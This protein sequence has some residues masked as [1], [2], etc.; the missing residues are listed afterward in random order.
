[1]HGNVFTWCQNQ[2]TSYALGQSGKAAE[3]RGDGSALSEK[4][5][6][7]LRGGWFRQSPQQCPVRQTQLVPP[8]DPYQRN[9][10][11][12]GEDLQLSH[13]TSLPLTR[14]RRAGAKNTGLPF[15]QSVDRYS[16]VATGAILRPG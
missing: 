16:H 12:R 5:S 2:Y 9:R 11:S 14:R 3:D 7:V 6:R 8:R 1:M 4:I 15:W 10:F 13:F